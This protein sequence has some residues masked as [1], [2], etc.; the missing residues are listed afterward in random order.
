MYD[1]EVCFGSTVQDEARVSLVLGKY[2]LGFAGVWKSLLRDIGTEACSDT[3]NS[4]THALALRLVVATCSRKSRAVGSVS[5]A[6]VGL[7]RAWKPPHPCFTNEDAGATH[8]MPLSVYKRPQDDHV[9]PA[10]GRRVSFIV[11]ARDFF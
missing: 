11:Y 8:S 10:H 7:L 5:R 6:S 4:P 3:N 1:V 9:F 2:T